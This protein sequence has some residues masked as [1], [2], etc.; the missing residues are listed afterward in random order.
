MRHFD[1]PYAEEVLA[2]LERIPDDAVPHWGKLRKNTLIEH[3]IFTLQYSMGEHQPF[4]VL[5]KWYV[6]WFLA[7]LILHGILPLPKNVPIPKKWAAQGV[8]LRSPGDLNTLAGCMEEYLKHVQEGTLVPNPH[9]AF[10]YIGVDGWD[11]M[12]VIH[13]EHHLRQFGV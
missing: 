6:R 10:G 1:Y 12:H 3:P 5:G 2:R 4:P 7:P 8:T 13:F 11:R 9:P